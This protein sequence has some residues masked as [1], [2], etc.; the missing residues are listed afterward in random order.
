[1]GIMTDAKEKSRMNGKERDPRGKRFPNM[2]TYHPTSMEKET[3]QACA[4]DLEKDLETLELFFQR[5]CVLSVGERLDSGAIYATLRQ[6]TE[7]WQT[8]PSLSAWHSTAQGAV[9]GLTFALRERYAEFPDLAFDSKAF[10][11]EW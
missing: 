3:L 9:R 1:M 11:D 5:G 7:D 8:A 2:L 10:K 6:K 4:I